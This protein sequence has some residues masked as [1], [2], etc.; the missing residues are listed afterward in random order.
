MAIEIARNESGLIRVF[1]VN[2]NPQELTQ[3]F[4]EKDGASLVAELLGQSLPEG[5]YE[6]FP[7][8]DLTGV[9]LKGYLQEGYAVPREQLAAQRPRLDALEGY[10]LLVFS[11]AF[12]GKAATLKPG[13][14][15]T[16]I[17]TFGE[18]QPDMSTI[19]LESEAAQ[20]GSSPDQQTT[21]PA[22]RSG[23]GTLVA[24]MLVAM[25]FVVGVIALKL[26]LS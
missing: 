21:P 5:G 25:L 15:L 19:P 22:P 18:A 16:L 12:E 3:A 8:K 10:V 17:G 9:G 24:V 11:Q 23:A 6:L 4:K 7:V 14:D 1:A 2:R 20:V 13:P 26:G